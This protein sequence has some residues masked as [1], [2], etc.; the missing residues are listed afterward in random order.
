MKRVYLSIIQKHFEKNEQMLFLVGPR[1]IGKTT[2]AKQAQKFFK[3][4]SYFTWDTVR[5]RTLILKGQHFIEDIYPLNK[6][7]DSK[8]LIV[9]DEIHKYRDWKNWLRK[10]HKII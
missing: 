9:F 8:P 2:I 7:R 1:Q 4:S 5:D 3:E 10:R 6:I